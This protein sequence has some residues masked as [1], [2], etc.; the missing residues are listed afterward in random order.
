[1]E[2]TQSHPISSVLVIGGCGFV[3]SH[4]VQMF[5][6]DSTCKSVSVFS[7]NPTTNRIPRVEY[8][9]GDIRDKGALQSILALV[10]PQIVVHLAFPGNAVK[11]SVLRDVILNGTQIA[12]DCAA[13]S[14]SVEGFIY[15]ATNQVVKQ[16]G[17]ELT[18]EEAVVWTESSKVNPYAKYKALAETLVLKKNGPSLATTSLRIPTVYGEG[19]CVMIDGTIER[20]RKGQHK[21]QIGDNSKLFN[22]IYAKSAASA[23]VLAAK[24]LL[25]ERANVTTAKVGGEAFFITDGVHTPFWNFSRKVLAAAGDRTPSKEIKYIPFWLILCTAIIA[26]WFY[27]VITLGKL[28][29]KMRSDDLRYLNTGC[30][31]SIEKAK[32]RL[33]YRPLLDE[34]EAIRRSVKWYLEH[35]N[36]KTT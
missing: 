36:N 22:F 16:T 8:H 5:L 9:A 24:A 26:E 17:K 34:D 4:V 7:R 1:M 35:E 21:V 18:E 2:L 33:G 19:H 28:Q 27:W 3:G 30:M 11:R 10:K 32:Q 25:A 13:E 23:H 6:E 20:L 15:T 31:F 14:P 12:L 29:P